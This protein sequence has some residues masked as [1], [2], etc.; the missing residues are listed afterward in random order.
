MINADHPLPAGSDVPTLGV[1]EEF[2]VV[3]PDTGLPVPAAGDVVEL[4]NRSGGD[5]QPDLTRY[6]VENNTPVCR[7]VGE[8][9]GHLLSARSVAASAALR[10]GARLLAVGV[11]LAGPMGQQFSDSDRYR[12]IGRDYGMLAAEH[13]VCGCHVHVAVP[14]RETAVQVCNHLRPWLPVLLA[15]TANSPIHQGLDT[16]YA[17]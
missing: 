10:S 17:S 3:D 16:R 6:L 7:T 9:R 13:G 15:L 5:L 4:A 11:P 14:D 1:E 12:R 2:L 8:V